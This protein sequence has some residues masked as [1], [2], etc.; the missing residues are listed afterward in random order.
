MTKTRFGILSTSSIVPRLIQG[1]RQVPQAEIVAIAARD[2]A[3]AQSFAL[4]WDIPRS[5]GGYEALLEAPDIDAIYVAML[6]SKHYE[7]AKKALEAGK[8]VLCEKPFTLRGH[9]AGELF[10]IAKEKGLLIMEAQK[11]LFLPANIK[12][13]ELIEQGAIGDV[14][15]ADFSS[16][17]ATVY[18]SWMSYPEHGGGPLTSSSC[19]M[20]HL[21]KYLLPGRIDNTNA[22]I[23]K[24]TSLVDEQCSVNMTIDDRILISNRMSTSV[25]TDCR[26]IIYGTKGRIEIPF[27]WKARK[28]IVTT[29]DGNTQEYEYPCD[30]EL[31]YEVEHFCQCLDSGVQESPVMSRDMSVST[32]RIVE[33]LRLANGQE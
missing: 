11:S 17:Y 22:T 26:A 19:Y 32:V 29:A 33:K 18:D 4:E 16:S 21:V 13:K 28:L 6:H 1:A 27:Y 8:H 10:A 14:Y 25:D 2:A 7:W 9:E 31:M 3:R 5:Y 23:T 20:I 24:G 30:H 12:A 15:L